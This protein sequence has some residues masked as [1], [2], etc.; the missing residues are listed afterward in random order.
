M[1][2]ARERSGARTGQHARPKEAAG[3]GRDEGHQVVVV[4]F[5]EHGLNEFSA[6]NK[7]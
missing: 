4:V 2:R 3:I 1:A 7:E 6:Q 5:G